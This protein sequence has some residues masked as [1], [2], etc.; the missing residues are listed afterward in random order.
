M[1]TR[2]AVLLSLVSVVTQAAPNLE[3]HEWGTFTS[4]AGADGRAV[5]WQAT[6]EDLPSFVYS[7][8]YGCAGLRSCVMERSKSRMRALIRMETPVIYFYTPE[9][10]DVSL[11]VAF[12]TGRMTEWYPS[13]WNSTDTLLDW[14]TFRV[15]PTQRPTLPTEAAPNHYYAAREVDAA[16][17]L[18]TGQRFVEGGPG[19]TEREVE[20]EPGRKTRMCLSST[21]TKEWE[22]FLFY[23]GVGDFRPPLEAIVSKNDVTVTPTETLGTALLFERRG[24]ALGVTSFDTRAGRQRVSRPALTATPESIRQTVFEL[25]VAT[26]LFEKEARAMVKTWDDS[27][28]VEGVRIFYVVPEAR[29]AALLPLTISPAPKRLVR[30]IVGRLELLMPEQLTALKAEIERRVGPSGQAKVIT[31][32]DAMKALAD[33]LHTK[34]GRFLSVMLNR[35]SDDATGERAALY[36]DLSTF[37]AYHGEGRSL[38]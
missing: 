31:N 6:S 22:R 12:P 33:A 24:N 8:H 35:L 11:K 32:A 7:N 34:F 15:D 9:P 26:G 17:V 5:P 21:P 27:W 10:L 14:G 13:A 16:P 23:R 18:V 4:I 30:T 29:T 38:D 37:I 3:V 1:P 2:I 36:R 19:C 25:L 20:F 28:F